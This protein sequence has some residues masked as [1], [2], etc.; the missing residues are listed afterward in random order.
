MAHI[1]IR[2]SE[3]EKEYAQQ[4]FSSMGLSMSGAIK[5]FIRKSIQIDSLPFDISADFSGKKQVKKTRSKSIKKIHSQ[6][7][8]VK[9]SKPETKSE[10]HPPKRSFSNF[11][12]RDL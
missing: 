2:I 5:L 6:Q 4:L 1:Q 11:I 9:E 3:E 12:S 7:E 8:S 10:N